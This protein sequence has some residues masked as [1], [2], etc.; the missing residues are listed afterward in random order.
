M[1]TELNLESI[2]DILWDLCTPAE[3]NDFANRCDNLARE[4]EEQADFGS[5]SMVLVE[6][7]S[8]RRWT[9]LADLLRRSV[10]HD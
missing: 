6:M 10:E 3:M 1:D 2:A 5:D 9:K 7:A 4:C 8:A